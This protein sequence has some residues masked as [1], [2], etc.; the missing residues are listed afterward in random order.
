MVLGWQSSPGQQAFECC[1]M[2]QLAPLEDSISSGENSFEDMD[3]A[4]PVKSVKKKK[5]RGL[6]L[7]LRPI[8]EKENERSSRSYEYVDENEQE[9]IGDVPR[10]MSKD[11]FL[12][13]LNG[14]P[15]YGR[16]YRTNI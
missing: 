5:L 14:I 9:Q 15:H 1:A 4:P 6:L 16:M 3:Y 7:L 13:A 2:P 11:E 8:T 12:S 10:L